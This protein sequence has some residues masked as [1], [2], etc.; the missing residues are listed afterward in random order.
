[1]LDIV[2]VDHHVV[3]HL[4]RQ[5]QFFDL[6]ASACVGGLGGIKRR[7]LVSDRRP[8]DLHKRDP[9]SIGDILHQRR[10]SVSRRRDQQQQTHQVRPF[11]FA[12]NADL[13]GQISADHRQVSV[14]DQLISHERCQ[15]ARLEFFQS[16]LNPPLIDHGFFQMHVA[17]KGRHRFGFELLQPLHEIVVVQAIRFVIDVGVIA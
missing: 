14:V 2:N 1:M 3:T 13:L 11:V 12:D 10:F 5:I 8:V 9:Q 17:F 16:Q 6:F 7:D 15:Y 4:Q